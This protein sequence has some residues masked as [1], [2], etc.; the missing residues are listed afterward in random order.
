MPFTLS[1][2]DN[3]IYFLDERED[4][5]ICPTCRVPTHPFDHGFPQQEVPSKLDLS[6]CAEGFALASPRLKGFLDKNCASPIEYFE[7]GGGYYILRPVWA[8]YED[9][10]PTRLKHLDLCETCG[11][12]NSS[13]G[14]AAGIL[15]GQREIGDFDLVRTAIELGPKGQKSFN[16]IVGAGLAAA[17]QA[18]QLEG[19]ECLKYEDE[20]V[21]RAVLEKAGALH[22]DR[23]YVRSAEMYQ[24]FI[25]NFVVGIPDHADRDYLIAYAEH[26]RYL[27][28]RKIGRKHYQEVPKEALQELAANASSLWRAVFPV[29]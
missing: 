12:Y 25:D 19:V 11:R 17:I 6:H 26:H 10:T 9:F 8:V 18:E 1:Y 22:K 27:V 29:K 13:H 20:F 2:E 16:L 21:A 28:G 14:I 24:S 3:Y 7:T 15:A 4:V 5:T 23:Q